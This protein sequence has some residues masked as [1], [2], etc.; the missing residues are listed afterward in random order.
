MKRRK[1]I[2]MCKLNEIILIEELNQLHGNGVSLMFSVCCD[3]M[4]VLK[5]LAVQNDLL[6]CLFTGELNLEQHVLLSICFHD[7]SI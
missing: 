4:Y 5:L 6:P 1:V 7:C 3:I 2:K